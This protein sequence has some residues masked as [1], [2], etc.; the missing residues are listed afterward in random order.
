[1]SFISVFRVLGLSAAFTV[2]ML[3]LAGLLSYQVINLVTTRLCA[4]RCILTV[5]LFSV[6]ASCLAS[7]A[8]GDLGR[9]TSKPYK[10]DLSIFEYADRD[11]KLQIDRVMNLLH[12]E[13]G[14]TVADIGAGSGWF[15]VRAARRVGSSGQVY[16]VDINRDYVQH[17]RAR[18][19][20]EH[21]D[22]I[23]AVV[24]RAGDPL[25]PRNS[26]DA[27]L[28]LKTY[29]E[30]GQPIELLRHVRAAMRTDGRL[31]IID[32]NGTGGDH[33]LKADVVMREAARAGFKF[34][35]Q[36]D[37]VKADGMDYFL[38]FEPDAR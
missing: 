16:A 14:K 35:E 19:K 7:T 17:I 1:M 15:S 31:G 24:G 26:I 29:H 8:S 3:R 6:S 11:A 28:L 5:Q 10:G 21:L 33:G 9:P 34:V 30:I 32:K 2:L 12:I 27:A 4:L 37:F 25:L 23:R 13:P 36:H 18:A 20:A 22:N 38:I